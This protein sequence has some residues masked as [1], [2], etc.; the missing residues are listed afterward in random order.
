VKH[1]IVILLIALCLLPGQVY[2]ASFTGKLVKVLDGDTVEVMH[3]GKAERIRL[4]QIDCPEKNQPFGQA[5]KEYV[6]AIAAHKIVT[7]EVETVDRYGRT[8]GEVFLPDDA[9]LNKQIFRAGYAWQYKRYSKNYTYADLE[10]G[11]RVQ[12]LGLWQEK[13]PIPPWEWR[14]GQRQASS[15]QV[16]GKDFTCGSKRYCKEMAS[17]SKRVIPA[18]TAAM[19]R[20]ATTAAMKPSICI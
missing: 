12:R 15:V 19:L 18:V 13:N 6:L 9:N 7:V 10:L 16:T 14:R 3:N 8:V 17:S 4:A 2:A 1:P 20:F 5:A 11:A